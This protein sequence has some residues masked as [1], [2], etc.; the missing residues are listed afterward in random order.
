MTS[1]EPTHKR[2]NVRTFTVNSN[3]KI[4]GGE[5]VK[6]GDTLVVVNKNSGNPYTGKIYANH[7][8]H[9]GTHQLVG[10]HE[11]VVG[12]PYT[13]LPAARGRDYMITTTQPPPSHPTDP[14]SARPVA[15]K[16]TGPNPPPATPAG[17]GDLY[18]G[19]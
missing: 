1:N 5:H 10:S 8:G 14:P 3:G 17:N 19:S 12:T 9:D 16:A 7:N 2:P 11:I 13:I 15:A 4:T 6:V 18:V